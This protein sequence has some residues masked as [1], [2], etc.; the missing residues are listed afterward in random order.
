MRLF[1]FT[2]CGVILASCSR[3][4]SGSS[5][6]PDRLPIGGTSGL[7]AMQPSENGLVRQL[8]AARYKSLYSFKGFPGDGWDPVEA[9]LSYVNGNLYGT[10]SLGGAHKER[11]GGTVFEMSTSGEERVLYN[12][13][14]FG[15]HGS[16][17]EAGLIAVNGKLYGTTAQGGA[18]NGGTVFAMSTSGAEHVLY[19]FKGP[20]TDAELPY[21][22]LTDVNGNFFGTTY[23]GGTGKCGYKHYVFGCG[24][25]Y[26]VSMSGTERVVHSFAEHGGDGILPEARLIAI[27]GA[28]YGTTSQGGASNAGTIFEVSASGTE[29]VLYNFKGGTDGAYPQAGLIAVNGLLYG[30]TLEGGANNAGTVFDVSTSGKE[31]V[32]Y[33]FGSGRADGAFPYAG[34][35]DLKGSL[36]GTTSGGGTGNCKPY[37]GCGTVFAVSTSGTEHVL[38]SFGNISGDGTDPD[39]GLIAVNGTLFGT[40]AA[41]GTGNCLPYPGCGTVFEIT[42]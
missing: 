23:R 4:T 3:M 16:F 1:L 2:L 28:V 30:T 7:S 20:P 32:L 42:P 5:P 9:D 34:L 22:S 24:T 40:T 39:A 10:T 19:S 12:F 6:L 8:S 31:H 25:V 15:P 13:T 36:Y 21:A 33:S 27:N 37:S 35:I 26:E 11:N 29:Y 17:P 14:R 38:Y 18:G 41:G